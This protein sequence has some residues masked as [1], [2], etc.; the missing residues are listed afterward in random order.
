M[1]FSTIIVRNILRR[2]VRSLLTVTG[3]ALAIAAVV[4]LLGVSSG[5]TTSLMTM[6]E[7]RGVDLVVVRAGIADRLTS[8]LDE[9]FGERI[10][11]LPQVKRVAGSLTEVS[12]FP[13]RGWKADSF[14]FDHLPIVE[15]RRLQSTDEKAVVVGVDLAKEKNW[16]LGDSI[17]IESYP[18]QVVG[19]F[20]NRNPI[21]NSSVVM[22]LSDLQELMDR[23]NQVTEFQ[24]AAVSPD[25]DGK[26][27]VEELRRAI[28]S[29][30]DSEGRSLRLAAMPTQDFVSS[31]TQLR[32]AKAMAWM[33]SV[34]ALIIGGVGILNTMIMSVLERTQ[35]IGVLRSLG[36]RRSRIVRL[37][38]GE[39]MLLTFLGAL[40][41]TVIAIGLTNL[42]IYLSVVP[43]IVQGDFSPRVLLTGL[44]MAILVGLF[45]GL[46][47]AWRGAN[48]PPTEALRYE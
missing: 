20:N 4:G 48:L 43:G 41:G 32:L 12:A 29:M 22:L 45:G 13:I 37:I 44:I 30:T 3:V 39:S 11:A 6:Y 28:E 24:I 10:A 19:I 14:A 38:M 40:L 33:T 18:F 34:I 23:P 9:Q 17:E 46:Y 15:G 35:E 27:P 8:S 2:K 5:F 26:S 42:L 36:W 7:S 21:E 1:R 25:G 31:T 47:P 16:K